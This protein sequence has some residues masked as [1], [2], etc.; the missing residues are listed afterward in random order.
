MSS[1]VSEVKKLLYK[2]GIEPEDD[3]VDL[4]TDLLELEQKDA[5]LTGIRRSIDS[6]N[7]DIQIMLDR[8][9]SEGDILNKIESCTKQMQNEYLG[10]SRQLI[11]SNA[12]LFV[13]MLEEAKLEIEGGVKGIRSGGQIGK[14]M[15]GFDGI[16]PGIY[17]FAAM[18]HAGK[19]TFIVNLALSTLFVNNDVD[20]LFVSADDDFK[21]I[22]KML[23]ACHSQQARKKV[24][25]NLLTYDKETMGKIVR[26]YQYFVDITHAGRLNMVFRNTVKDYNDL[27]REIQKL[28]SRSKNPIV[29]TDG[30]SNI[31][32]PQNER[33]PHGERFEYCPNK[34]HELCNMYD[35]P[36]ISTYEIN[37]EGMKN[38]KPTMADVKGSGKWIFNASAIT[39]IYSEDEESFPSDPGTKNIV[40]DTVKSK[41]DD[42]VGISKWMI[43]KDTAVIK[44]RLN[45]YE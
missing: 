17:L 20:I 37:K 34:L 21:K 15:D 18:P 11:K 5:V 28:C 32:I 24:D 22:S 31:S 13:D 44:R 6:M 45:S 12:E 4:V 10:M 29:I 42:T 9:L 14:Y 19:T 35:I 36:I 40:F 2:L 25:R 26:S 3:K 1:V 43:V 27:E 38:S 16:N 8:G 41:F 39:L 7:N 23:L 30:I 33:V